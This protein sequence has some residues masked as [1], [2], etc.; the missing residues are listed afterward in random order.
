[1]K[2]TLYALVVLV[3]LAALLAPPAAPQASTSTL[4]ATLAR[5][6]DLD[7]AAGDTQAIV[8]TATA[9]DSTTYTVVASPDVPRPIRMTVVDA[10]SSIV[11]GTV[12]VT[13]TLA[14]GTKVTSTFTFAG[15]GSTTLTPS[16]DYNYATITS[17]ISGVLTGEGVGDTISVGTTTATITWSYPFAFGR[18]LQDSQGRNYAD[19][20][21][22]KE[23]SVPIKIKTTGSSTTVAALTTGTN[24]FAL[25]SVG[26]ILQL[27]YKGNSFERAITAKA[28]NDSVTVDTAVDI[29]TAG[30][31]FRFKTI[32]V[33]A[34]SEDGWIG[35]G[36][37]DSIRYDINIIQMNG[38][39]GIDSK[40]ECRL[41]QGTPVVVIGT[42]NTT[43]AGVVDN[44]VDLQ[45]AGPFDQCR[46]GIKWNTSDDGTDTTTAQEQITIQFAGQLRGGR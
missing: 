45:A 1:M 18:K 19:A 2:K 13:G 39:G 15:G 4:K 36:N 35:V 37:M 42:T 7:G 9:A 12:T 22:W 23:L 31:Y 27:N 11:S 29:G 44:S 21:Y 10:N 34:D 20:F 46:L 8:A 17:V 26:D 28:S 14:D 43:A 6:W 16:P 40:V 30:S 24:P 32:M 41:A 33:G 5:Y 3:G 38:T 25:L